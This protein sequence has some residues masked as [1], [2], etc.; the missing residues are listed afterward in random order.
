MNS[1]LAGYPTRP[2]TADLLIADPPGIACQRDR[3]RSVPYDAEYIGRYRDREGTEIARRLNA[4]RLAMVDGCRSALD[5]GIGSG[6]FLAHCDRAGIAAFGYDVNPIAVA[7]LKAE[8]RWL[9]PY[10]G[11]AVD[12]VTLWDVFEH[13]PDPGRLLSA[14]PRGCRVFL[15]MPI[16][17]DLSRVDRSK[18]YRPDEHYWYFTHGG[19][20]R[21]FADCGYRLVTSNDGETLAGRESIGS[22]EFRRP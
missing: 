6:E 2:L 5:I 3:S 19:L 9:D 10:A 15:S 21:Y 18:H 12:G 4:N 14:L 20:V 7:R 22:F 16:F 17:D 1:I 13:L 8:G 11:P